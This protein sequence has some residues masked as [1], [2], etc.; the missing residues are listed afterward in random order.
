MDRQTV[1]DRS[2]LAPLHGSQ[3]GGP[4]T[5][6]DA[7]SGAKNW[8]DADATLI[9]VGSE[10]HKALFCRMLLDTFDPYRPDAIVWPELSEAARQQLRGLPIWDIAVQTENK[11]SL[12][13]LSYAQTIEDSLLRQAIELN[14]FEEARHKQ[15][16]SDMLFA[17]G[18]EIRQEPPYPEP[19]DPE[20]AFMV[21]GFSECIDSFFAFGLFAAS[22]RFGV[23]PETL[24]DAFEPVMQEECRHILFFVNWAAWHRRSL[25]WWRRPIF[26]T[27]V[28]AVWLF[29]VWERIRTARDLGGNN[30]TMTGA[31]S[32]SVDLDV[33]ELLELCLTENDKRLA[34]YDPRL[35][36]PTIMPRFVR[37]VRCTMTLR[38]RASRR[39]SHGK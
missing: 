5:I 15:L 10:E 33:L 30:F 18:I 21:T 8:R 17:Y 38:G 27:K 6:A 14:G 13:V 1:G 3:A 11:A 22:R 19:R 29:L 16:L 37:L 34:P 23:F 20:W 32:V 31:K 12:S 4:G 25:R 35:I 26:A 36:R 24:A 39:F 9:P 7:G 2:A 28:L